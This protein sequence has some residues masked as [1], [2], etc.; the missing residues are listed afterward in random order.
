MAPIVAPLVA[1]FSL[2]GT[3]ADRP[4]ATV[5]DI[6]PSIVSGVA[7]DRADFLTLTATRL[8]TAWNDIVFPMSDRLSYT[9]VQ[10]V[11]LDSADGLVGSYTFPSP[12]EGTGTGDP[13]PGNVAVRYNKQ[14]GGYS[15]GQRAGRMYIAGALDGWTGLT[16]PNNLTTIDITLQAGADAFM[17]AL[18]NDIES[19]DE[20]GVFSPNLVVVHTT[21]PTPESDPV[22]SGKT[23]I[24]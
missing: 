14:G 3:Y 4:V 8:G 15:R 16:Q 11:D 18:D 7:P 6:E 10:Y 1:R 5:L 22:Y 13:M 9:E 2:I 17:G 23:T 19:T 21:R 20:S 12:I 24:Q